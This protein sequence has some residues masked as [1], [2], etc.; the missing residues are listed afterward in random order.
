MSQEEVTFKL[1]LLE[2]ELKSI[3]ATIVLNLELLSF[4]SRDFVVI[5]NIFLYSEN[6]KVFKVFPKNHHYKMCGMSLALLYFDG[7]LKLN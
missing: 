1:Y 4:G 3:N 7:L 6:L 2:T 5:L